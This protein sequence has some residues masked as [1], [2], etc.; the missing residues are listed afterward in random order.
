MIVGSKGFFPAAFSPDNKL[1]AILFM[2]GGKGSAKLPEQRAMQLWEVETGKMLHTFRLDKP[3]MDV[4]FFDRGKKILT[5]DYGSVSIFDVASRTLDGKYLRDGMPLAM[6]PD[7]KRLLVYTNEEGN[8]ALELWDALTAKPLR[9]FSKEIDPRSRAAISPNG[10]WALVPSHRHATKTGQIDPSII[11]L[12]DMSKGEI[13]FSIV[14]LQKGDLV[15]FELWDTKGKVKTFFG[16]DNPISE[17]VAFSA[18]SKYFAAEY[19]DRQKKPEEKYSI[20]SF[21]VPSGKLVRTLAVSLGD[22]LLGFS[23]DGKELVVLDDA[24]GGAQGG[25]KDGVDQRLRRFQVQTGKQL[26]SVRIPADGVLP[27]CVLSPDSSRLFLGSGENHRLRLEI[28]DTAE[29]KILRRLQRERQ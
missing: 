22:H 10:K 15:S 2:P 28:W 16:A 12:W 4:F 6:M 20:R 1:L 24:R 27:V 26:L 5:S 29:G 17:P 8:R 21:E 19:F 3:G 25:K 9:K 7:G 11:Q 14:A 13:E 18:D 23:A